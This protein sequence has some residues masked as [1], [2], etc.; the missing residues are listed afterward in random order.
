MSVQNFFHDLV[1][2]PTQDPNPV[3][4]NYAANPLHQGRG[5][6]SGRINRIRYILP[7]QDPDPV[8]SIEDP[9]H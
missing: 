3:L 1:L 2:F 5:P 4:V 8:K 9:K 6:G 7:A